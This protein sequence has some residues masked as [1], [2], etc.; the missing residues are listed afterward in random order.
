M[1][2]TKRGAALLGIILLLG[3]NAICHAA[4]NATANALKK[5]QN[6]YIGLPVSDFAPGPIDGLYEFLSNDNVLYYSPA[7]NLL[8]AGDIYSKDGISLTATRLAALQAK[9]FK[10]LP[11][12]L[13]L[14]IGNGPKRIIEFTDPECPYCQAYHKY[15]SAHA[16][17]V[18]RYIFFF[19]LNAIHPGANTKAVQILC[20]QSQQQAFNDVYE[21]KINTTLEVCDGGKAL[22]AKQKAVG[23]RLGINGTPTLLLG[24]SNTK[25]VGFDQARIA[26][27][28]S[29]K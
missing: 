8:F 2:P 14:K 5:L 27:F 18:T 25:V 29:G 23:D 15:I 10:Q 26:A 17:E 12:E 21:R 19:P 24:S 28:L 13:A 1:K 3:F 4:D 20:A 11:L 7:K 9:K 22:L 16:A 6:N